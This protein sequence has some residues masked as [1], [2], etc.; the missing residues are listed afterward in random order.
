MKRTLAH[1]AF[2]VVVITWVSASASA[3]KSQA[4]NSGIPSLIASLKDQRSLISH[5]ALID[6]GNSLL[7]MHQAHL[8]ML[9]QFGITPPL[10]N[11]DEKSIRE[12]T[13]SLPE[14][15]PM[16]ERTLIYLLDS[17]IILLDELL[18]E[19]HPS[20]LAQFQLARTKVRLLTSEQR[21][22]G[23]ARDR[24]VADI[25]RKIGYIHDSQR[26]L[27]QDAHVDT[28]F[29]LN[30]KKQADIEHY[31]VK[32]TREIAALSEGL[33]TLLNSNNAVSDRSGQ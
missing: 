8:G 14:R 10:T 3:A 13:N 24:V 17:Q 26:V 11:T 23:D 28:R 32:K 9:Q 2:V 18:E 30:I 16:G 4:I 22:F 12:A 21:V 25:F 27:G 5:S 33:H 6:M 29:P 31:V 1:F 20:E 19:Q 7:A 15:T